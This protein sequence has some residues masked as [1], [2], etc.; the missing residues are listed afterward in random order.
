MWKLL[1]K[2]EI[3]P[4]WNFFPKYSQTAAQKLRRKQKFIL[5][6]HGY[7]DKVT[8]LDVEFIAKVIRKCIRAG[9][10][11]KSGKGHP[12]TKLRIVFAQS[13]W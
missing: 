11:I 5:K 8:Q 9:P 6:H 3:S 12:T 7:Q 1:G 4:Q 13:S 2:G 10:A